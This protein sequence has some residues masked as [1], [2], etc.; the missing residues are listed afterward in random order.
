MDRR[1][2]KTF[3]R[4]FYISQEKETPSDV[5]LEKLI[6]LTYK[7]GNPVMDF[8]DQNT[9]IEVLAVLK[10]I[11]LSD[12]ILYFSQSKNFEDMVFNSILMTNAKQEIKT[13]INVLSRETPGIKEGDVK[14]P[15]CGNTKVTS[16]IQQLRSA[17]EGST[18]KFYCSKC[19][20][21]WKG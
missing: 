17:D 10:E 13:K 7:N 15:Y 3:L 20:R 1:E 8:E 5:E 12:A 4:D 19:S 9:R 14:C 11:P 18:V 6:T 16:T 21:Q 2:Q